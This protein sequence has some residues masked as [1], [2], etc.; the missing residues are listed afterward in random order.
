MGL[1]SARLAPPK[2]GMLRFRSAAGRAGSQ[3]GFECTCV[4]N[5]LIVLEIVVKGSQNRNPRRHELV[6]DNVPDHSC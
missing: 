6:E 2:G 5:P 1:A 3:L 4:H